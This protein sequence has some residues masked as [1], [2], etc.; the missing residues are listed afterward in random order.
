MAGLFPRMNKTNKDDRPSEVV[1]VLPYVDN[2]VLMQ[3]RD[4]KPDIVF[5]G[6]WGFFG[7]S[8]EDGEKP[9]ETAKRELFE[10]IGYMP[11]IL[12]RLNTDRIP[13]LANLISHSYICPLTV[14]V[15]E[16]VLS[17]GFD[18]GLFT[19]EEIRSKQLFSVRAGRCYPVINHPYI[20]FLVEKLMQQVKQ[21]K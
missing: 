4:F 20:E 3:L 14:S 11:Q 19:L 17:E 10:E 15:K 8:I 9:Q 13:E 12:H 2:R 1:V 5:P 21:V 18:L 6:R 7:G 16:I